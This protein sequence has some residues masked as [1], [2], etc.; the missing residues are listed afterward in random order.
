MQRCAL[1]AD[2]AS[3][4]ARLPS[5]NADIRPLAARAPSSSSG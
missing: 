1:E 2:V 5:A 4:D 3:G